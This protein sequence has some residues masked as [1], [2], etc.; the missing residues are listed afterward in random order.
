MC[1]PSPRSRPPPPQIAERR[2]ARRLS[3]N[4]E[5]GSVQGDDDDAHSESSVLSGMSAATTV[6]PLTGRS[7][8]FFSD[9]NELRFRAF[10]LVTHKWF[11]RFMVLVILVNCVEM[12]ME[13]PALDPDS[14]EAFVLRNIDLACT[15]LFCMEAGL[16]IFAF[17]F[18]VYLRQAR[19]GGAS[20]R[21]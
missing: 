10:A 6:V 13:R 17:S 8:F 9:S 7:L 21:N 11:D 12:A 19:G 2:A 1:R 4:S 5:T 3:R 16:K 18:T 14:T 15:I 20:A